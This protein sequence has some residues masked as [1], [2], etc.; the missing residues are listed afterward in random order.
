M[1]GFQQRASHPPGPFGPVAT[2]QGGAWR[3]PL[4]YAVA[5]PAPESNATLN[6]GAI[7]LF[8]LLFITFG[9]VTDFLLVALHL[10][11]VISVC[12]L[13]FAIIGGN[14]FAA[15]KSPV[16][17]ALTGFSVCLLIDIPFSF[18]RGNSF[19][20]VTD[21]W[22]K[23]FSM[24]VITAALLPSLRNSARSVKI[25]AWS[26]L[27]TAILGF[28]YG[29]S[30]DGRFGLSQGLYKGSNELATAMA[31][32]C[33]FWLFMMRN[34]ASSFPKRILSAIPLIPLLV[35]L[36]ETAS[37]AGLI[38]IAVLVVMTFFQLSAGGKTA[39]VVLVI[40]A[41]TAGAVLM[42]A[43]ARQRFATI[44]GSASAADTAVVGASALESS[45]QRGFLLK[46]SLMLTLE[47]PLFGVG[48][49][50]F[51]VAEN[52]LAQ[53]EGK[54]GQWLGTHNT[55]TQ[56]SSE[57][58]LPALLFFVASLFFC[59]RELKTA[60][61]IHRTISHPDSA[62][63]LAVAYTLRL[64]LISYAV[65][66]CFEHIGYTLFYP[67]VAGIIVAFSRA[68]RA[69]V[70]EQP[71]RLSPPGMTAMRPALRTSR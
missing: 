29:N 11:L 45:A 2:R 55:Y 15:F 58:G 4:S 57:C 1:S 8:M 52:G 48:P 40:V 61:K 9:R 63:Y 47:H 10:P 7:A 28:V 44:F 20:L 60:E 19:E 16:G 49:G 31:Q 59:W 56:I 33:I 65:F 68:S 32:G 30:Q 13:I 62:G 6:F 3:P 21:T 25:L 53:L 64:A 14:L 67:V 27:A 54:R 22:A 43:T 42:P 38:V 18:W 70:Q 46:R 71:V 12:C 66:F 41:V 5:Q 26:F 24:F 35:I 36:L 39:M 50:Q 37:R 51:S 34:P 69:L 23:S 17:M